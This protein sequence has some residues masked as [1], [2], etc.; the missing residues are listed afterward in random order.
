MNFK[1]LGGIALALGSSVG[2]FAA[3]TPTAVATYS[4]PTPDY[5]NFYAGVGVMLGVALTVM[6]A[7]RLKGFI[8]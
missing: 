3:V 6:L 1:K 5:T 2:A 8:R 7:R 4:V